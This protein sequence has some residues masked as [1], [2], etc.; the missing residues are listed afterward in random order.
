MPIRPW[1]S[2]SNEFFGVRAR[3][4]SPFWPARSLS[5]RVSCGV[6]F[7][8]TSEWR[9]LSNFLIALALAL[10]V[11]EPLHADPAID[12]MKALPR[13]EGRWGEGWMRMGPGEPVRFVGE[14]TVEVRLD[15][16]LLV[17]EGLHR[18]PDRS[19]IVHHAFGVFSWDESRKAYRFTTYVVNRGG[20]DYSARMEGDAL[21][22]PLSREYRD[23]E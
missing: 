23:R 7:R 15:G 2:V 12:A 10:S 6:V 5:L 21:V 13:L 4:P 19:K 20:G 17:V 14:E 22:R 8:T 16:R 18:T 11:L 3:N 9:R 1:P